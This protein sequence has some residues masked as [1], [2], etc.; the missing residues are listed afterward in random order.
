[1]L[2]GRKEQILILKEALSSDRSEFVIVYGRRRVGKTFLVKEVLGRYINFEMTGIQEGNME[3]QLANFSEKLSE[4]GFGGI[5]LEKPKNWREAF[6]Q[7]KQ[8]LITFKSAKKKII[9]LD[10]LPWIA[11]RKSK[12]L[13]MLGHF[14][15]DWAVYNNVMLVV[16]GSAASWMIN[17]V[18]NHKG[19]L[20]NRVTR[21]LP[22]QPFTLA[23]TEQF[24]KAKKI[25]ANRYQIIQVY[26]ALGGIPYYLEMLRPGESIPQNI[27]RLCFDSHGFLRDEF[28]RLYKSLFDKSE[29]HIAVVEALASKWK[30]LTR[31]EIA[32]LSGIGV[33]GNLSRILLELEKSA[34]VKTW[35]PFGSKKK[36]TIYRLTDN[37]SLFYLKLIT[38]RKLHN[39]KGVF[40][41]LFSQPVYQ[42]WCGYAF[43]NIC[44]IHQQQIAKALG[45]EYIL[46]EFASYIFRGNPDY[47]GLQIDLLIDRADGIINLCEMKFSNAEY[48]LTSS[49]K[50]ILRERTANFSAVT[51]TRKSVFTTLVTT[52][53]LTNK[54]NHEDVVQNVLSMDDLFET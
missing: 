42:V 28:S 47:P 24:L 4:Y 52:Y 25:T 49:Y 30:G 17:K 18:L 10:E 51:K 31:N 27:D 45:I 35:Y 22:L 2:V 13:G 15:N 37:F 33:G 1:M 12:F 9:F 3:D 44:L 20:H 23:E 48:K 43:E 29:N 53:G 34:F 6:S 36:S 38:Q 26:M 41:K 11:T 14:W 50:N 54:Q 32:E 40:L 5:K 21:Y 46:H 7:L 16:C 19:G 8:Y 39:Q